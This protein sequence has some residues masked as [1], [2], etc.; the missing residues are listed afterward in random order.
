M[1]VKGKEFS[2]ETIIAALQKHCNFEEK[3]QY[4]FQSGDI[5]TCDSYPRI[6][7]KR[8]G[9]LVA[10]VSGGLEANIGQI[11]FECSGYKKVGTLND[12]IKNL[13]EN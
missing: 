6:I 2:E 8:G 7:L 10:F 1:I 11:A 3:K 9:K 13:K 4:V 5:V 12:F